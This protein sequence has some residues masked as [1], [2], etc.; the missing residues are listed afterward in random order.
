ML[1]SAASTMRRLFDRRL[2]GFAEVQVLED[3]LEEKGLLAI[4][5]S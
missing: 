1:C 5:S 4:A 2:H 3:G